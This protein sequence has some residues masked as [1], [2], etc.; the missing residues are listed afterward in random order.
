MHAT[1]LGSKMHYLDSGSGPAVLLL[2]GQATHAQLYRNI[3]P[4]LPGR[5]IAVD[6]IGMGGSD[7]PAIAYAWGDHVRYLD[8]FIDAV[9]PAPQPLVIVAQDW[10]AT[11]GVDWARRHSERVRGVAV[12]GT[13]LQTFSL[14]EL[15]P[16]GGLMTQL[17]SPAGEVM[18]LEQNFVMKQLL[19]MSVKTKLSPE[20]LAA[21]EAPYPDAESRTPLLQ[22]LRSWPIDGAP[23][24]VHD[25]VTANVRWLHETRVPRLVLRTDEDQLIMPNAVI[26][27][28]AASGARVENVGDAGHFLQEDKPAEISAAV[29]RWLAALA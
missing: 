9:I 28:L 18:V 21:Y 4:A 2:H 22:W 13:L 15:G 8:A 20:T 7:K 27:S 5:R 16:M 23:R 11:L 29:A 1:V 19:P 3:I 25:A 26:D 17:R 12:M 24:D 6:L 10:G 14:A